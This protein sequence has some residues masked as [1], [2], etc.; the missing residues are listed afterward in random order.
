MRWLTLRWRYSTMMPKRI[1]L[2][3]W[4]LVCWGWIPNIQKSGLLWKMKKMLLLEMSLLT[5]KLPKKMYITLRRSWLRL[6]TS[7]SKG[8]RWLRVSCKTQ[9]TFQLQGLW[10]SA[11]ML[12]STPWE[13]QGTKKQG[14]RF[15]TITLKYSCQLKGV[16]KN[17]KTNKTTI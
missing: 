5:T 7:S 6:C 10:I 1:N 14:C 4:Q 13:C 12:G 2:I 8:Q 9:P 16:S 17:T 3:W 15:W 11:E